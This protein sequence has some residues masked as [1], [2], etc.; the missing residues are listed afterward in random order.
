MNVFICAA[1]F[2]YKLSVVVFWR[3]CKVQKYE[4][5]VRQDIQ[6]MCIYHVLAHRLSHVDDD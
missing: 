4:Y 3:V 5:T 1:L 2:G 6:I